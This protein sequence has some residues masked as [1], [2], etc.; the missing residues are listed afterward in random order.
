MKRLVKSTF[1]S[2]RPI[3]GISR[4]FT[5]ELTTVVNAAPITIPTARS[6]MLPRTMNVLNSLS[7]SPPRRRLLL[8]DEESSQRQ[9]RQPRALEGVDGV[10]GGADQRL[11]MQVERR[12]QDSAGAGPALELADHSVVAGVPGLVDDVGAGGAILWMHG[13][14][15]LVAPL[16][17]G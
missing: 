3:G 17:V 13:S 7:I 15:D 8:G 5:N 2:S 1:P 10:G 6:T 16:G 4:S 14:D 9:V 11:A 12:V